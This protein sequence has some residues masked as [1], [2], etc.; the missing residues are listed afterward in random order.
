MS[1]APDTLSAA[2]RDAMRHAWAEVRALHR[3][4]SFPVARLVWRARTLYREAWAREKERR[5]VGQ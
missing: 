3:D 1:L 2:Y 4:G 5:R